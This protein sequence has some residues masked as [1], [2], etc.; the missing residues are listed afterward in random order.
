MML[1]GGTEGYGMYSTLFAAITLRTR[2]L[3]YISGLSEITLIIIGSWTNNVQLSFAE[4]SH[5]TISIS[6]AC[7]ESCTRK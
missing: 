3:R 7:Q 6:I 4:T 1:K 2:H 5:Q